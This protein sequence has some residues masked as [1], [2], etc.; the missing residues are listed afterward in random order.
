MF[1]TEECLLEGRILANSV[2][3]FKQINKDKLVALGIY[4][5]TT[6]NNHKK[7]RFFK[8]P[9]ITQYWHYKG[10]NKDVELNRLIIR[11]DSYLDLII[12]EN[13]PKN[14]IKSKIYNKKCLQPTFPNITFYPIYN[15]FDYELLFSFKS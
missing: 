10:E 4:K 11:C 3:D 6:K 13:S 14:R 7:I 15:D 12:D 2:N 9:S 5:K 1:L 8:Y